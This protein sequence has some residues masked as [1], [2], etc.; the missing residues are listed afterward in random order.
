MRIILIPILI[1]V[2][3]TTLLSN[4]SIKYKTNL[5]GIQTGYGNF[6]CYDPL[7]SENVNEGGYIPLN[8]TWSTFSK[9]HFDELSFSYANV[10]IGSSNKKDVNLTDIKANCFHLSYGYYRRI[11]SPEKFQLYGGAKVNG[12]LALRDVS[13]TF[14]LPVNS[15]QHYKNNDLFIALDISLASKIKLREN[16]LLVNISYSILSFVTNRK[17]IIDEEPESDLLF[18]PQFKS[19]SFSANYYFKITSNVYLS[20]GYQ[21]FYYS[22]PRSLDILT[23]KG[24]HS[25]L[26]T[27]IHLKF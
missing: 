11:L 7:E 6:R 18:F 24:G 13:Y 15:T 14:I 25:Q 19:L 1:I 9:K 26:L 16:F 4:D 27:G 20:A 2:S 21:F 17:Y 23:T 10:K 12:Y 8:F 5:L 22:Y 3:L